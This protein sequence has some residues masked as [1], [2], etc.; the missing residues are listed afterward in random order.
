MYLI[1]VPPHFMMMYVTHTYVQMIQYRCQDWCFTA[2][3]IYGIGYKY[4]SDATVGTLTWRDIKQWCLTL[5][6]L[7]SASTS[8]N[9]MV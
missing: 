5:L 1:Y 9:I 7:L 6:R 4:Q 2:F 8:G 3:L